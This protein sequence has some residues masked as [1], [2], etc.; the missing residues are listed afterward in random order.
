MGPVVTIMATGPNDKDL[1]CL[2]EETGAGEEF[3]RPD[4]ERDDEE[5]S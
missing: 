3:C 1:S 5:Y 2:D 4:E